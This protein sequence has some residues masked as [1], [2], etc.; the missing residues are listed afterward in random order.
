MGGFVARRFS[1]RYG[2]AYTF[3]EVNMHIGKKFLVI[4]GVSLLA[5]AVV[6]IVQRKVMPI[7]LVGGVLPR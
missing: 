2:A 4:A 6:T 7:P 3:N 1:A 5:F